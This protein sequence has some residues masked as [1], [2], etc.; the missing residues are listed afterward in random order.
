M[1]GRCKGKERKGKEREGKVTVV[2]WG[3]EG[4]GHKRWTRGQRIRE[5]RERETHVVLDWISTKPSLDETEEI[6]VRACKET[7]KQTSKTPP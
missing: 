5:Q 6:G 2:F 4:F 3:G 1:G 7:K